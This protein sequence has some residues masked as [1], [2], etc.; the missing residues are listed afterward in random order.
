MNPAPRP[1]W[2]AQAVH[3]TAS[4]VVFAAVYT[5]LQLDDWRGVVA[6]LLLAAV[7]GMLGPMIA[8]RVG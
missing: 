3:L 2:R 7:A 6:F 1:S 8:R 5:A 4:L